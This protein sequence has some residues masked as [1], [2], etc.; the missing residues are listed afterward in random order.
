MIK[1]SQRE[2]SDDK[3][4]QQ[5][6]LESRNMNEKSSAQGREKVEGSSIQQIEK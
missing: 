6:L 2:T 1:E 4:I 5:R 3:L